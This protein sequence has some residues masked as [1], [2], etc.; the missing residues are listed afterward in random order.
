MTLMIHTAFT[1]LQMAHLCT[2][3][4]PAAGVFAFAYSFVV[5]ALYGLSCELD[6]PFGTDANDLDLS[7]MAGLFNQRCT[8]LLLNGNVDRPTLSQ[9]AVDETT[10]HG[11]LFA[12]HTLHAGHSLDFGDEEEA[13]KEKDGDAKSSSIGIQG[14]ASLP[15]NSATTQ[16]AKGCGPTDRNELFPEVSATHPSPQLLVQDIRGKLETHFEQLEHKENSSSYSGPGRVGDFFE[17]E[18]R[19]RNALAGDGIVVSVD[20]RDGI[21]VTVDKQASTTVKDDVRVTPTT[22]QDEPANHDSVTQV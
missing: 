18:D 16:T 14:Q 2:G 5:W 21:I 1:P 6:D 4:P 9:E 15:P 8:Q 17:S 10:I 12:M 3:A 22:W 19:L 11:D 20:D 13:D 7:K